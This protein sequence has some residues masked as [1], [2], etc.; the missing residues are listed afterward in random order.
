MRIVTPI[1]NI[2][3]FLGGGGTNVRPGNGSFDLGADKR[4]KKTAFNGAHRQT[5]RR[6]WNFYGGKFS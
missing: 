1:L 6:T 2:Y 5:Q 3:F 4:P